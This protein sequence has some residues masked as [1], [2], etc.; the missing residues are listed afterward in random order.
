MPTTEALLAAALP[1]DDYLAGLFD[2]EGCIILTK[3]V[4]GGK[5]PQYNIAVRVGI[6][7]RP[8]VDAFHTRFGGGV[9]VQRP[10]TGGHKTIWC[11]EVSGRAA[12]TFLDEMRSRLHEKAEQAWLALEF[13]AARTVDMTART[14][15]EE[16]A[17]REGFRLA[18]QAAKR[19]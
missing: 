10:G 13:W 17:L 6:A 19:G 16:L 11:W 1:S 2:G 4:V 7:Y 8:T 18:L 9:H 14:S 3:Q 12:V 5:Q 15:P